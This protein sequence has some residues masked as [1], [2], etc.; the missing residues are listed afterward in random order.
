[1]KQRKQSPLVHSKIY[2][3]EPICPLGESV[4]V[5]FFRGRRAP[6]FF[7]VVTYLGIS[8]FSMYLF[9]SQ[10]TTSDNYNHQE[11]EAVVPQSP[12]R[13]R[14]LSRGLPS[15]KEK[16]TDSMDAPA[17]KKLVRPARKKT[18]APPVGIELTAPPSHKALQIW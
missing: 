8:I 11:H 7:E 1:M 4:P 16:S 13:L 15:D 17:R 9:P 18:K 12:P 2:V 6:P 10:K 3:R 5:F 14:R